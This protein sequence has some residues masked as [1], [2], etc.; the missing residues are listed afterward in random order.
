MIVRSA[1]VL[2]A[3]ML[4]VAVLGRWRR[5][6]LGRGPAPPPIESARRCPDCDAYVFGPRPEPCARPDCRFRGA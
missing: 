4:V 6:H 3:L 2:L 1:L 5:Q